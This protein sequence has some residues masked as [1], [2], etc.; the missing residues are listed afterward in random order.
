MEEESLQQ[1]LQILHPEQR[2]EDHVMNALEEAVTEELE[3]H[4]AQLQQAKQA[5]IQEAQQQQPGQQQGQQQEGSSQSL[6]SLQYR[7]LMR[8]QRPQQKNDDEDALLSEAVVKPKVRPSVMEM[9][10]QAIA[11]MGNRRGST[12]P[13]IKKFIA[14][15]WG[16]DFT[17]NPGEQKRIHKAIRQ[18]VNR[19]VFFQDKNLYRLASAQQMELMR[20]PFGYQAAILPGHGTSMQPY[21]PMNYPP[22]Q[23]HLVHPYYFMQLQQNVMAMAEPKRRKKKKKKEAIQKRRGQGGLIKPMLLSPALAKVCGGTQMGRT[24]V[25]KFVWVYIKRHQLQDPANKK[26]IICDDNLRAIFNN[27]DRVDMFSMTKMISAHLSKPDNQ[28]ELIAEMERRKATL[29][30]QRADEVRRAN[31]EIRRRDEQSQLQKGKHQQPREE[32]QEE[33]GGGDNDNF[34]RP[35]ERNQGDD[36][37]DD[38]NDDEAAKDWSL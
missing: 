20:N 30:G 24:D 37:D 23:A 35:L 18:G 19:G 2:D 31:E 27:Q 22:M 15:K 29:V 32:E 8:L 26:M 38:D 6:H 21:A 7:N 16:V 14:D 36:D 5:Q 17:N 4:P 9:V 3:A 10:A 11:L 12:M 13:A 34:Y 1:Q 28:D 25:V 33:N